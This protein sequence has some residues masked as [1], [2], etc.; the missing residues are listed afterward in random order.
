[1]T[2]PAPYAPLAALWRWAAW[3]AVLGVAAALLWWLAAGSL[4]ALRGRG[5]AVAL[6]L[7]LLAG[8]PG[9]VMEARAA[10]AHPN[11]GAWAVVPMPASRVEA[12][13][14]VH[15]HSEPSDVVATNVHCLSRAGD[16][17]D[18][19]SFW[20]S[21]YAQ[22]SVLVEGWTFAP[23]MVGVPGGVYAPFWDPARLARNDAAFTA[24]T[25][26][27][28]RSLRAEYGVRWLVVDRSVAAE[29]P[30]LADLAAPRFDN[31][32]L[33]VYEIPA[34]SPHA[35]PRTLGHDHRSFG[36]TGPTGRGGSRGSAKTATILT[37][38]RS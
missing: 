4:P 25:A 17:C 32:R 30:R 6:T 10:A 16:R 29:S 34:Y 8:A 12:A 21:A 22:R 27:G 3:L 11:G 20:L 15:D 7:V 19:R 24:P 31:G 26:A 33:A 18:A 36:G 5:A 23:R 37:L 28:L 38:R 9:L 35:A 13:R 14:W 2:D 1:V